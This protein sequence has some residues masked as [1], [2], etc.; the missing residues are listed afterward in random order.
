MSRSHVAALTVTVLLCACAPEE[1]PPP[2]E[3]EVAPGWVLSR[4]FPETLSLQDVVTLSTTR[5]YAVGTGATL[6]RY[7]EGSWTQEAAPDGVDAGAVLE[8]VSGVVDEESGAEVVMTVGE[9]GLVL[10]RGESGWSRLESGTTAHL[11]GVWV[12]A[13]DDAFIVGDDGT[14]LR[15]S[16]GAVTSMDAEATQER[17]LPDGTVEPYRIP[18]ALKSV[19]G[20]GSSDVY[21]VGLGGS[22]YHFD[23]ERFTREDS[24]TSRPFTDV[25]T[26][27]GVLAT[28]TDGVVFRRR[29][30]PD[31]Q[32]RYWADALRVPVPL[33]LQGV[34]ATGGDDVY[35]VGMAGSIFHWDGSAWTTTTLSEESH[36]RA[37]DG[38]YEVLEGAGEGEEASVEIRRT[39]FVV[40][41]GGRILRGPSARA[42]AEP[43]PADPGS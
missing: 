19:A 41:A 12:R 32:G 4:P 1:V 7:D 6:L 5:A 13:L 23:G 24:G 38:V 9:G 31:D 34:W 11:F 8:S 36:L 18:E 14:I 35:A 27:A 33:Y 2:A 37:I 28:A 22:A 16:D 39:V 42:S 43:S 3:T 20:R 17:T 15:W 40:G 26:G 30:E 25:F 21:V 29:G 10:L